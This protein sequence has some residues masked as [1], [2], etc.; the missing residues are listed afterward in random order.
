MRVLQTLSLFLCEKM[1]R[2][3]FVLTA[4]MD[5]HNPL[6]AVSR[7]TD[8]DF[9]LWAFGNVWHEYV[10]YDKDSVDLMNA[11]NERHGELLKLEEHM[12]VL[13][14]MKT[15]KELWEKHGKNA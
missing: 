7:C 9:A 15:M 1:V 6:F 10:V 12:S 13:E 8:E 2:F 3:G 5:P 14:S 4:F 11:W